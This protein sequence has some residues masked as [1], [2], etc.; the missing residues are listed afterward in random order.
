MTKVAREYKSVEISRKRETEEARKEENPTGAFSPS[1]RSL[2][3]RT[4]RKKMVASENSVIFTG[5]QNKALPK[6]CK[7][8]RKQGESGEGASGVV[9]G[10]DAQGGAASGRSGGTYSTTTTTPRNVRGRSIFFTD[11]T[12]GAA[13][14]VVTS[15]ASPG[16]A[17]IPQA[18]SAC[19]FPVRAL[20]PPGAN[21]RRG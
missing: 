8:P 9:F 20:G 18:S 19:A 17:V 1:P 5:V 21:S 3:I 6:Q 15:A 4:A 7:T 10:G 2:A 13:A 12:D 11:A 14:G 16:S